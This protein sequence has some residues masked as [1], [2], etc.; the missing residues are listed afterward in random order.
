MG[1]E[2]PRLIVII[3]GPLGAVSSPARSAASPANTF[4]AAA[5]V[6][7]ASA[8]PFSASARPVSASATRA[9]AQ[10]ATAPAQAETF[11]SRQFTGRVSSGD[12]WWRRRRRMRCL[13]HLLLPLPSGQFLTVAA[14]LLLFSSAAKLK[15]NFRLCA[16]KQQCC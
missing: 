8:W 14:H 6:R 1:G 16:A 12:H 2:T 4:R 9:D 11:T 5:G 15:T 7:M 13:R 3:C 10:L